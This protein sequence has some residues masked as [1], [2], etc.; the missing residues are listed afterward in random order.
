MSIILVDTYDLK[1]N[2]KSNAGSQATYLEA[3]AISPDAS[4]AFPSKRQ[5][6][7]Q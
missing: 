1:F 5:P 3:S 2:E 6:S 4:N 7:M